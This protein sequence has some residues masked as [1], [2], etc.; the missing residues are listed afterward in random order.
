MTLFRACPTKPRSEVFVENLIANFIEN[1]RKSIKFTIKFTAK[2][3]KSALL[4]RA[5]FN[6]RAV[7]PR[8][9]DLRL[10]QDSEKFL[11]RQ[12]KSSKPNPF[13]I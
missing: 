3:A 5:V 4:G 13:L 2:L 1:G 9:P 6:G 11:Q 7:L 8:R 12:T 10:L